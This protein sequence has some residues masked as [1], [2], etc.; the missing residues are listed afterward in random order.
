MTRHSPTP[1]Q[2]AL[3]EQLRA[4]ARGSST[5]L[6]GIELLIRHRRA[7]YLGAP[8]IRH[9]EGFSW[10]DTTDLLAEEHDHSAG[11][12]RVMRIAASLIDGIPLELGAVLDGLSYQHA[13]LVLAAIAEA[14]GYSRAIPLLRIIDEELTETEL[15]ALH[16]WPE[17]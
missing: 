9:D 15:P 12:R 11:D 7:V 10:V 5:T 4:W 14:A 8:W 6:A 1:E 3:E 17:A 16:V 2:A 13:D